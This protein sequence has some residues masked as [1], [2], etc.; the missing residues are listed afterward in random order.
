[1]LLQVSSGPSSRI[2][3]LNFGKAVPKLVAY[4]KG[5]EKEESTWK[6]AAGTEAHSCC[7]SG[8]LVPSACFDNLNCM[9]R[10][11]EDPRH[12]GVR[13][14]R[15]KYHELLQLFACPLCRLSR[16]NHRLMCLIHERVACNS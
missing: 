1:M 8:V 13:V 6:M 3:A 16:H 9:S 2:V 10:G 7:V 15:D 4:R 5:G 14:Q 12:Q 11:C